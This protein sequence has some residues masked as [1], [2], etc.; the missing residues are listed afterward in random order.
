LPF[1]YKVL[2]LLPKEKNIDINFIPKRNYFKYLLTNFFLFVSRYN[3]SIKIIEKEV[4]FSIKNE[5]FR[6]KLNINEYTQCG[7]YFNLPNPDLVRLISQGKGTFID[8]GAN[9]G[10]FSILASSYFKN[11]I[12]FEPTKR[13]IESFKHNIEHND[14]HNIHLMECGLSDRVGEMILNENPLN[15]GGNSLEEFSKEMVASSMRQDWNS[16]SV[17]VL[18]LDNFI[19]TNNIDNIDLIKID[20]ES[21]EPYVIKGAIETI[22][23]FM[24]LIYLEIGG[25]KSFLDK[26]IEE[27]PEYYDPFNPVTMTKLDKND[28]MPW[29]I[30]FVPKDK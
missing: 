19:V 26:I 11:V 10:F 15:S 24:P 27:M 16:Y 14:I 12:S 30:L 18:T 20:V 1:F 3:K 23:N 7:L 4:S 2:T 28:D 25:K 22:E 29:D 21:H 9:I 6:Y 13:T 8:I 17:P 5:T